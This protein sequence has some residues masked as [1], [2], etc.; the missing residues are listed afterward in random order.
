MVG[1][2]K[3]I[4]TSDNESFKHLSFNNESLLKN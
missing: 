2:K 1:G 3:I 4:N